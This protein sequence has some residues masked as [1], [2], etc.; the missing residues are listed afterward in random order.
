MDEVPQ[1]LEP[2]SLTA[3]IATLKRCATQ[4]P[5]DAQRVAPAFAGFPKRELN[6]GLFRRDQIKFAGPFL[7][8]QRAVSLIAAAPVLVPSGNA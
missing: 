3:R 5:G 2:S 8:E 7:I 4:K 1:R 6:R